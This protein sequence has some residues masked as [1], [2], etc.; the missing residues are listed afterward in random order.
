MLKRRLLHAHEKNLRGSGHDETKTM[1]I[2]FSEKLEDD[3]NISG[4]LGELFI[5]I[6]W[7]FVKLD[8]RKVNLRSSQEALA[9]LEKIE[10]ILGVLTTKENKL[11]NN[12]QALIN[13][14]NLARSNK[15]WE[16]ADEVRNQL[17]ELG[18]LLE[19]TPEGTIWKKK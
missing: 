11:D 5:W 19:D 14:R 18:I 1:L 8:E 15:E 4:A 7:L 2:K 12:I 9:A 10:S 13:K 3:L 16:K 17:D 6:N